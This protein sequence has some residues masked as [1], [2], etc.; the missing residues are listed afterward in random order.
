MRRT[1]TALPVLILLAA[2]QPAP[3]PADEGPKAAPAPAD[4]KAPDLLPGTYKVDP[5]HTTILFRVDH[6]GMS[7]WTAQ[8][9]RFDASLVLDPKSPEASSVTAEI[10]VAS[11]DSKTS[12]ALDFDKTLAGPDWLD[13]GA[14][15]KITFRSTK[16]AMTGPRTADITGDLSLKGVTKPVILKATFNDGYRPNAMDGARV[17]FSATTRFKRSDFGISYGIP[18]PRTKM[19]VSDEVEVIIETEF[20]QG[21]PTA[22]P[23]AH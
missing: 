17:G 18:A 21:K 4:F 2:C 23:P 20:T 10:D 3:K 7:K 13:A 14:H 16:V 12:P 19:G 9:R 6:V 5:E 11:I 15:P 22:E 8:F 1:L